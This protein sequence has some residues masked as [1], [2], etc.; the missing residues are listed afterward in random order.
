MYDRL[1]LNE[2]TGIGI[3]YDDDKNVHIVESKSNAEKLPEI[4][5]KENELE[6]EQHKL[7]DNIDDL[8]L[9]NDNIK[10]KYKILM[11]SAV[12]EIFLLW[13]INVSYN[14]DSILSISTAKF[15]FT[16][17]NVIS[18]VI[19]ELKYKSFKENF[20]LRNIVLP[21]LIKGN[22][23]NINKL[24]AKI[25]EMKKSYEFSKVDISHSREF[26]IPK[27]VYPIE[28]SEN[29]LSEQGLNGVKIKNYDFISGQI[30]NNN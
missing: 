24:Q 10:E 30:E 14:L 20:R 26:E 2:T 4:I 3:L 16:T 13:L 7:S 27:I 21:N 9:V 23:D 22:R 18:T 25:E 19:M 8:D 29:N 6:V 28:P 11:I 1:L 17:I 12:T 15:I 5:Q